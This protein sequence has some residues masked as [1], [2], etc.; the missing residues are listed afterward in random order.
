MKR[1]CLTL[2]KAARIFPVARPLAA[3][4]V[5]LASLLA[6][7]YRR[8]IGLWQRGILLAHEMSLPYHQGR[9]HRALADNLPAG[10]PRQG[11]HS[12]QAHL[13]ISEEQSTLL[14]E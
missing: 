9:L 14:P 3:L 6:G 7:K 12:T 8:A 10:D 4:H 11:E 5:G 1:A 13:L 2:T